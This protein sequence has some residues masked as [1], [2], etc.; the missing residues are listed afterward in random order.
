MKSPDAGDS[1]GFIEAGGMIGIIAERRVRFGVAREAARRG[2]IR[3]SGLLPR[4]A[5]RVRE[6]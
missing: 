4:L 1:G 2:G 5:R 3:P 6:Q